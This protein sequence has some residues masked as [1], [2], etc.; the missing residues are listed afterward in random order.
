MEASRPIDG[1]AWLEFEGASVEWLL[2][3]RH[4]RRGS[5]ATVEKIDIISNMGS[6]GEFENRKCPGACRLPQILALSSDGCAGWICLLVG[7]IF[8]FLGQVAVNYYSKPHSLA[9]TLHSEAANCRVEIC[10]VCLT[11]VGKLISSKLIR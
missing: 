7:Q 4:S 5:R 3:P 9:R 6:S 2:Q 1:E 10:M 11:A 8:C